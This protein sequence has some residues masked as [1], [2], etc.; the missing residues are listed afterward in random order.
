MHVF[1]YYVGFLFYYTH[2]LTYTLVCRL[3]DQFTSSRLRSQPDYDDLD[4]E[5]ENCIQIFPAS[6]GAKDRS[7]D[8]KY[9][10]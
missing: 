7:K 10:E 3:S 8:K 1:I 2:T 9:G 6:R 5:E 4:D